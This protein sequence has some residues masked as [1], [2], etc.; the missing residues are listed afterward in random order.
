[1]RYGHFDDE[2]REYVID[3]PDTPLPWINYLGTESYFG[4]ISNTAG[5]YS[6]YRDARLRRLTRYRYNNAPLD[7]GGRYL[8]VRDDATG[9]YWS[10]SWQP[11]PERDLDEYECRHGLSYTRITGARGGVRAEMLYFAPLDETLEV[12]RARITNTRDTAAELSLFSSVEFCLWDA[13]DDATNYQRN[14][15]TGQVEVVD[16]TIYHKTEYRERRDHFAYFATNREISGFDTQREAFLGPYRGYDRPA[17]VETGQATDSI[18]HGWQPIGSHHVKITVNPGETEEVLFVLGYAENP[19]DAKFDPPGSQT[20]NKVTVEP[21]I[22]RWLDPATVEQGFADL[23]AHWDALLGTVTVTTP[24][25]DTNRMVNIW[26]AYQNMVTFNLSRSTSLYEAGI[27]RGMGFRDSNQDLLGFVHMIPA[28]ARERILD[29]AATQKTTGGAYHQYQPLTK[30]GNNDIG[31]GFNDDPLW[32]ILGVAA[33]LKE[34]GDQSILDEPVPFD[35]AAGSEVSLY[36]HLRRSLRYTLDRLGPHGL[37]L[38]G[39]ADWNDCLNLNCFSDTPGEPFQTTE[40]ASGGVAESVFI[41]GQ[42]VLAAKELAGIA[43]L[44]EQEGEAVVYRAAA[45]KMSGTIAE[46]GWD[47][48][49]FRRA[50]DFHGTVIGSGEND[51]GQIFVEPQGMCVLGGVGLEDG[52]AVKALD[53]VAARLAT[54]HGIVLQQPAYSSYRIELGEISSYPPGYKENG[55]IFCHTN[56]WIMIAETMVGNGDR[57]F[58]YYRRINP[59]AREDLGEVHRCEPYVYAQMIAGRDAPTHGEAKNSWLTGTAAW[60]FAAITQ[61]ILGL[62]PDFDGLRVDPVLPADWTGFTATRRFRGATYEITVRKPAGVRGRVTHLLVEG[63]RVEGSLVPLA[64]EGGVV[65]V[66]AIVE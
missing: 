32:L 13:Q 14:F 52:L 39:R 57:A 5:G 19:R 63:E 58:D 48:A 34:T 27:G 43:A 6:F 36:E 3:R 55:G 4:I 59:S 61:W 46:H 28:R 49:W 1:M 33:Y 21:T 31:E 18:A 15:N 24:D 17:A 45:E 64:T 40:N 2:Q 7:V 22:D 30:R 65:R 10:P 25:D 44:R 47:G 54:P 35:N 23:R 16:G 53:S 12:W 51:E 38:I 41:A 11:T 26:N 56:P 8:Y 42:F 62:R 9:D 37:P 66:E 20:I 60:N 50:Y 29:I